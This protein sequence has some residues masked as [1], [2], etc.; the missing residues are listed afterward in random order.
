MLD[1]L[2][3]V[4]KAT[5]RLEG[6][7]TRSVAGFDLVKADAE[8]YV[9]ERSERIDLLQQRLYAEGRRSLL[10]VLQGM[11]ASG[12]DGV[13]RKV[14]RGITP[15]AFQVSSFKV[16]T[17][18]ELAR[19]YL[20]RVHALVPRR[21]HIGIFNRS[22]Y[23]DVVAAHVRG[24]ITRS[25]ARQRYRQINDFERMLVEEGTTIVK[26]YLHISADEQRARLQARLDDPEKRWKFR[27]GDLDDRARWPEFINAYERALA[28]TSTARAPWYVVPADRKWLR[29]A[30][31]AEIVV[32]ALEAM[33]PRLPPDDPAVAGLVV[34]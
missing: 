11:D 33:D 1:A 25:R 13:I 3:V 5:L 4:P 12:K 21:G 15:A 7:D 16:P 30:V 20:W 34:P 19:D 18:S 14:L 31:V 28:A 27:V 26:C 10:L 29:D 22:H 24:P 2:V 9:A 6:I 32:R 23:E 17:S 8:A